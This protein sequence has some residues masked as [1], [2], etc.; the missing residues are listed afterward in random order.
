MFIYLFMMIHLFGQTGKEVN[1]NGYNKFYY[2]N[3]KI[4]SE[5]TMRDG[6]PDGYW[7]T[8][9]PSGIIKSEGNRRNYELD[10]LWKFYDERGKIATEINYLAGKKEGIKRIWSEEGFI[11]SEE[12]FSADIKQGLTITYYPPD[13]SSQTKGK[14]KTKTLFDKGKENGTSYEYDKDG[15]IITILEYNYGVLKKQEYVNRTNKEGEKQGIWKDFYENGKTK[16]ETTYV[17]GK[18]SGYVKAFSPAGSLISIEKFV[19]DSLQ[20]E[21]PELSTKLEVRNEYYEDGSIKK[22]G[23]YL[24]GLEEGIQKEYSPEGKITGVKIFKEG[25]LIG[26]GLMNEAGKQQGSWV[27]YYSSNKIKSKGNY[28]DGL[29]VGDWIF[30]HP[31]GKIEQKGKYDKKGRPTGLWQWFYDSGKLLREEN[32]LNGKREGQMTEWNDSGKVITQGEYIDGM[33]EGKWIYE[34]QDFREEGMYKNDQKDGVWSSYYVENSQLKFTGKYVEGLPDGK[35]IS[36]YFDGKKK[37]VGKYIMGNKDGDWE[38]YNPDGTLL[39]TVSFKNDREVK[40]DGTK[41]KPLLPGE[42]AK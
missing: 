11:L 30:Y 3:G 27:E 40:F 31:N 18:K 9:L 35:H 7:K 29:K 14:I 34:I 37:E 2:E 17:G 13:D 26:E 25:N 42:A 8:Y 12:N 38:Y 6:R 20:K 23:T 24:L 41:I 21:V 10:S 22:T 19:G 39:L 15:N 1:P 28:E 16:S 32:Y 4:S 36:Y 33:K 5:G